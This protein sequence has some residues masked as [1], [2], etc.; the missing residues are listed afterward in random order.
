MCYV[1]L[2]T[3]RAMGNCC[4]SPENG[5]KNDCV[6]PDQKSST[7]RGIGGDISIG[8][9]ATSHTTV[10]I[11]NNCDEVAS[12]IHGPVTTSTPTRVSEWLD[13]FISVS[14]SSDAAYDTPTMTK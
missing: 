7:E 4:S 1:Y 9:L 3:S 8:A 12:I 14:S 13:D 5:G 6:V 11:L 2:Y 10:H